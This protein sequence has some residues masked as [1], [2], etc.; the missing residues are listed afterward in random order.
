MMKLPSEIITERL[1][2]RMLDKKYASA[3]NHVIHHSSE[4]LKR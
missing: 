4:D 3:I 2:L 1:E